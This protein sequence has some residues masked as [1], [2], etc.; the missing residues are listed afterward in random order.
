MVAAVKAFWI[1]SLHSVLAA[2]GTASSLPAAQRPRFRRHSVVA[3]G[4]T[5]R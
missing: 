5:E 4:G 3:A 2:G 1:A